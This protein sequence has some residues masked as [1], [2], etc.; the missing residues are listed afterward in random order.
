MRAYLATTGGLFALLT[1]AHVWRMVV[2]PSQ[3][4]NPWFLVTT[5]ISVAMSIWALRLL[6]SVR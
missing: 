6:R 5:V 4:R 2:E 1:A 3:T